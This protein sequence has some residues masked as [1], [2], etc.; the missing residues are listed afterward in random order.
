M[1][2][3]SV[4]EDLLDV[5]YGEAT[6]AARSRV[7]EHARSCGACRGE[8]T[9]LQATRRQLQAWELPASLGAARRA[10]W[11]PRPA[12]LA[13]AASLA[14]A[15]A[16][17][18]LL[19]RSGVG[20]EGE[21]VESLLAAQEARHRAEIEAVQA[22]T[23]LPSDEVLRHVQRLVAE[24]EERQNRRL[25]AQLVTF[26]TRIEERRR[27]DLQRVSAGLALLE[28]QTNHDLARATELMGYVL[29]A[30]AQDAR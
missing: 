3:A 23:A 4:R 14:L 13:W 1:D 18:L 16:A 22:R 25:D 19:A 7:D 24:A 21:R 10:A 15:F 11:R 17:G 2:C 6:T 20:G 27:E 26:G 9:S 29:Q 8:L 5:L 12:T 28:G 30:S